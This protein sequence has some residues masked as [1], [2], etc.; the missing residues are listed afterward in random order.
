MKK[1]IFKR[2]SSVVMFCWVVAIIVNPMLLCFLQLQNL[3]C[4]RTDVLRSFFCMPR[5]LQVCLHRALSPSPAPHPC[6]PVFFS[7]SPMGASRSLIRLFPIIGMYWFAQ[8]LLM[9]EGCPATTSRS[10]Q[11]SKTAGYYELDLQQLHAN[12]QE[13]LKYKI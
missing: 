12:R 9:T 6:T 5:F 7:L 3:P 11:L 10:S 8:V 4:S 1:K 13:N 2:T